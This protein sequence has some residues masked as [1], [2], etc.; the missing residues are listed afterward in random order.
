[1]HVSDIFPKLRTNITPKLNQCLYTYRLTDNT[2]KQELILNLNNSDDSEEEFNLC[3][4]II[5]F[6]NFKK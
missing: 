4:Q 2:H 6:Q 3:Q 5:E 1:M